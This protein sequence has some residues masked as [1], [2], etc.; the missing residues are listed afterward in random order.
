MI[1]K[2]QIGNELYVYMNGSLLYKR[3]LNYRYGMIFCNK[4]GYRPFTANDVNGFK[5]RKI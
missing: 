1:I 4:W 2:Q 5:L 3:W